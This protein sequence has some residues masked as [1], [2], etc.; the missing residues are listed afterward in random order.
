MTGLDA[1]ETIRGDVLDRIERRRLHVGAD[2]DVIAGEV[3]AAVGEYQRRAE[4]GGSFR[5][6]TPQRRRSGSCD[7][8]ENWV[9]SG[10]CSP[11]PTSR[12]CS[13]K[14]R[15]CRTSATTA[16]CEA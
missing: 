8:S 15:E 11:A 16:R 13:S 2:L 7:R 1:F 3:E 6:R 10:S 5:W 4:R 9:R 14:V 12:K